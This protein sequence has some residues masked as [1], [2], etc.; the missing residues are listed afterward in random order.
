MRAKKLSLSEASRL[1]HTKPST[2]LR[3]VGSAIKQNKTSGRFYATAND[4][5]K[6]ELRIPSEKGPITVEV[7]G[8]K[9]A[10]E[11]SDYANAVGLY[12]RTGKVSKLARFSQKTVLVDGKR[13]KL[14]TDPAKLTTLAEADALR[15]DQLYKSFASRQ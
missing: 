2:V 4:R 11:L 15:L 5:F 7:R 1:E 8:Y 3:H 9:Q 6:R 14:L 12:L 13:M 10:K